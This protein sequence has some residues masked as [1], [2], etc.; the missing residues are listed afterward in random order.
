VGLGTATPAAQFEVNGTEDV[1]NTLTLFPNGSAPTL[2]V[3]GTAFNVSNT[4]LLSFVS[5]QTFPDAGTITGVVAGTDLTGGGNNGN[6][7]LNLDITKVPQL[8]TA[9]SF[10]GN[11]AVNGNVSAT[12][13]IST[14]ATGTSPGLRADKDVREGSSL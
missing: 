5:G 13:L 14:V 10:T 1:R 4:G 11:Q 3:N 6:V 2:T 12:Q 7:T 9:N 8:A